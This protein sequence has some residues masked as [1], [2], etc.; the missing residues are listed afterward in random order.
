RTEG[1]AWHL[2]VSNRINTE[3]SRGPSPPSASNNHHPRIRAAQP[4]SATEDLPRE[5]IELGNGLLE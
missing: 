5:G 3:C 1:A 2:I 4:G